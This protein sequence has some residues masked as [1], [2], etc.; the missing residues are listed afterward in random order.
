[1]P[2]AP[3]P[4]ELAPRERVRVALDHRE[5]DRVPVDFL[6]TPEIW[7]RL[8]DRLRPS[9]SGLTGAEF[10][11]LEREAIL[12]HFQVDCRVISYD[13]FCA[14]PDRVMRPGA[15]VDWW[16]S[17]SRSTPNRMWRQHLPDGTD[18]DIWGHHI[19]IVDN[20]SG[21]YEEF[22]D[23]PLAK[24]TSVAELGQF[25]WPEPDWWDFQP[26]REV[27]RA[28]NAARP[29]HL[30]FRIGS[31]FELAWQLRGLQEFMMDLAKAPEIPHYIMDRLTDVCVE[32][33]RRVLER[34]GDSIDMVYFYDDLGGQNSLL[35]SKAMWR[36]FVRPRHERLIAVARAF[37]KKVMYHTDG[38]VRALI[39]E[40]IDMGVDVLNPLQPTAKDMAPA[41]LKQEFG[42]RLCFHG[43]I[44][45]V[46]TLRVGTPDEVTAEVR[47]CVDRLGAHGGYILCSSHHI[48]ADTPIE[49]VLAM[50]RLDL[51]PRDA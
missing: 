35:I 15:E 13:M 48:Q 5:P 22:V 23:W 14:P 45:I 37:G 27:T 40:L 44:D 11:S 26:V 29:H 7:E 31:I 10:F 4:D 28:L 32:N 30:R 36:K 42:D 41:S 19:R 8:V 21:A 38:A 12:R 33:T 49:N 24:C 39:P 34:A 20:P 16:T 46:N 43:G 17:L 47:G 1:M 25:D 6:A 50:Y 18:Y 2:D 3:H 51:R 9:T